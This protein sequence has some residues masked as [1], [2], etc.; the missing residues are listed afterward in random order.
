MRKILKVMNSIIA[1]LVVVSVNAV[2][3]A[4]NVTIQDYQYVPA[5]ITVAP[6]ETVT[7]TNKDSVAHTVTATDHSWDSGNLAPG[8]IYR[9]Q[10]NQAGS[11]AYGCTYHPDMS[12]AVIVS[13]NPVSKTAQ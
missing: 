8:A 6:G 3:V 13:G 9:H 5:S 1:C 4:H 10:F 11:Y 2:V 12:G 7:W